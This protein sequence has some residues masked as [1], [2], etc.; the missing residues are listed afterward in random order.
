MSKKIFISGQITGDQN[1]K[2]KF[3][4][5]EEELKELGYLV[6]NPAVLPEGLTWEEYMRITLA[7][8][9]V[10]DAILMLP[11]WEESEGAKVELEY[12]V[13]NNFKVFLPDPVNAPEEAQEAPNKNNH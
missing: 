8:L 11:D 7:M 2:D 4:K 9:S 6:M 13:G 10:C 5:K 3:A 1:Y 12:A